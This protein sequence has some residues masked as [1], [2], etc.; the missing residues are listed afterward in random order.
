MKPK[1]AEY[2]ELVDLTQIMLNTGGISV[3]QY[4][5]QV[6]EAH[7]RIRGIVRDKQI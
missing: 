2:Q 5:A 6:R 3:R 7:D 4:L 1:K